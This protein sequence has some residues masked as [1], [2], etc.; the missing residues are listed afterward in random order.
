MG[1]EISL[2]SDYHAR[3]NSL[4]N[5]CGILFRLIYRESP[6]QFEELVAALLPEE[7]QLRVG[8]IF[9]QQEKKEKSVPDLLIHQ[10]AFSLYFETKID[11]WFNDDQLDRHV[12]ALA[13][14]DG[15]K[16]LVCLSNFE[17]DAPEARFS[18]LINEASNHDVVVQFVNFETLV[19]Q[20]RLRR[21]SNA[22]LETV[23]EFEQYL[24]RN[25]L[26]PRWRYLLDVVNC[27]VTMDEIEAGAYMCPN[28]GGPYNH[29]RA[30]FLGTYKSKAV[31]SVHHIDAL[32]ACSPG[33]KDFELRWKDIEQSDEALMK[34]G[35]SM[36]KKINPLH[37]ECLRD[38]GLQIF[39]F[40]ESAPTEFA[41]DSP[42]GL[43]GS[44]LYFWD[45]ARMLQAESAVD[46]ANKLNGRK[47]SEF[48]H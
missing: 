14:V 33:G 15:S 17:T 16:V 3:E 13:R 19:E 38:D 40:G 24:D 8:P 30:R 10:E 20:V 1:R 29:V 27:G 45:I 32:V 6:Q 35:Q 7:A 23:D 22:L 26:L 28:T 18:R 31:R 5:H 12:Q 11:D 2:F 46:L 43:Q 48:G 47:W 44:K 36:L 42:G 25:D 21:L 37:R 41:K 34:R 9:T 39:L 4:T